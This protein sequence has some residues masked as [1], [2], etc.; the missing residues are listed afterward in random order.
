MLISILIFLK[1]GI[2][3]LNTYSQAHRRDILKFCCGLGPC[4]QAMIYRKINMIVT[5]NRRILSRADIVNELQIGPYIFANCA[6]FIKFT[7]INVRRAKK[8]P[9]LISF[10]LD[11]TRVHPESYHWALKMAQEALNSDGSNIHD[12]DE[13]FKNLADDSSK[14]EAINLNTYAA[15]IQNNGLGDKMRTL[16]DIKHELA[17][18]FAD[19]RQSYHGVSPKELFKMFNHESLQ[20][21]SI[22]KIVIAKVIG[23]RFSRLNEEDKHDLNPLHNEITSKWMCTFCKVIS[24]PSLMIIF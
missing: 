2:S 21:L 24:I 15:E 18:P 11:S 17:S 5:S 16:T 4:K 22:G 1:L 12:A 9:H 23:F 13:I 14:V 7:D 10:Y 8:K 6:G 20:M 19:N 3:L